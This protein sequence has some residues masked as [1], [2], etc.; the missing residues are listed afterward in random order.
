MM[1]VAYAVVAI[2]LAAS[3][4]T[5]AR[6][7]LVRD[8]RP[9]AGISEALDVPLTWFP[10]LASAELAGAAGVV[11]GLAVAPIGIAAAVGVVVY[12]LLAIGFHVRARDRRVASP[13]FMLVLGIAALVLRVASA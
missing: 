1:F 12:F 5:S 7:K 9:V 3:L 11:V 13:S 8:P 10:W 4:T 6:L 2:L